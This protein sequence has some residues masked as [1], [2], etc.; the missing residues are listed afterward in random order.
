MIP[1]RIPSPLRRTIVLS[2][3]LAA[4]AAPHAAASTHVRVNQVGYVSAQSKRAFVLSDRSQAG[5]AFEVRRVSDDR[6]VFSGRLGTSLGAWSDTFPNV[7]RLDFDAVTAPGTYR[8][9]VEG[10]ARAVSPRFRV[11]TAD[12]L[13]SRLVGNARFFF[14]AQR[15]GADVNERVLDRQPS[16][17]NDAHAATYE[18]PVYVDEV[19]QGDLTPLGGRRDAS[20]G[21]FDAGDYIK[22]VQ[23][24]SYV[25]D[26]LLMGLRDFPRQMGAQASSSGAD[27]TAEAR[28]GLEWLRKMWDDR[29]R[30][31][32]YQVGIGAGDDCEAI[33]GDHDI[34]RLPEA[35]D[36]FERGDPAF[37]YIRNRPLFRAGA[38]GSHISPNLAG[39]LTAAFALGF[40]V[41]K[42]R[43]P[44]FAADLL[45]AAEHVYALADTNPSGELRTVS[46]FD[47]YPES[48]WV[49]DLELG[50]AELSL[51]LA[52][53]DLP[54]GLDQR[55]P[56][57]YLQQAA[58]WADRWLDSGEGDDDTLNLFDVSALAHYE[59]SRA[60]G[61]AGDPAGLEVTRRRLLAGIKQQLDNAVE[62]SHEDPFGSGFAW[63]Q[64]DVT[65]HLFGLALT[66]SF[67]DELSHTRDYAAFGTRQVAAAL[68]ANAWGMSFIV[69]AGTTFPHCMQH[70]VANLV[71]SLDGTPPLVLGAAVNGSNHVEVFDESS[72]E[73]PDGGNACP[74]DGSDAFA[75]FTGQ[76]AR[77]L[78]NVGAWMSV[79]PAIDFT[80][81]V[82]LTLS[83]YI[84][85][86]F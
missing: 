57:F 34:W 44:E 41:Y 80:A 58:H 55:N 38:P 42:T 27:F 21:W 4:A 19:L 17:L 20:G 76:D 60:I 18:P 72:S 22:F 39:R 2:I 69:G 53:G 61:R 50:A 26:L 52:S 46:P 29:T 65:S 1:V 66:A 43:D 9:V 75:R 14:Q 81:S 36:R 7:H 71:G 28:F 3:G 67:Y 5:A 77:V 85:G 6:R 13:F 78:D 8:I 33:C 54:H 35:D 74:A 68:G 45:R 15:D 12:A 70:Q 37:R 10:S 64:F 79:E 48:S 73:T 24:H 30:T 16:H 40:Q 86:R 47:F 83:R 84:A 25:V 23:T 11:D 82:P 63:A 59:L 56:R 62:Q 51:A 32:Y 49:D 31:L